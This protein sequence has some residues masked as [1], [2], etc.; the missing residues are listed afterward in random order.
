LSNTLTEALR[1]AARAEGADLIGIAPIE[2]FAGVASEHHPASIFPEVRS[3]IVI[4]KRITR[5]CL[6]GIEEGTQF[7]LY[8]IYAN[9]WV[10]DR[11]LAV[12]T[13]TVASFLEDNRWEAVPLPD[14]PPETPTMGVSVAPGLPAPNVMV[15]FADAAVRAGLGEI[16]LTG[17]LMTPEFGHLQRIQLILTDAELEPSPICTH[18]VCDQC[19]ECA[20]ACPLGAIS[21]EQTSEVEICGK[22]MKV[23]QINKEICL[24]CRNGAM[25]NRHHP[26]GRPERLAAACMRACVCNL[27]SKG[28][29]VKEFETPFRKRPPWVIGAD[30]VPALFGEDNNE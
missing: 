7:S 13:V 20:R 28:L 14:L 8:A 12:T 27:E 24:R 19:G 10:P 2:R 26:S 11:F 3:V 23:A 6:R 17:E 30:G 5:G 25:P 29:L 15:D 22:S 18:E 16:G 1:S 21:L 9:N 4:G